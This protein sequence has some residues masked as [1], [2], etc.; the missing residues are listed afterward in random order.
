M[1][2]YPVRQLAGDFGFGLARPGFDPLL[3][4]Q[5]VHRIAV[6]TKHIR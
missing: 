1:G 3:A 6:G 4:A 5:Q 2:G